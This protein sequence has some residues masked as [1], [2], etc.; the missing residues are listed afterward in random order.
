MSKNIH[1]QVTAAP[2]QNPDEFLPVT[3]LPVCIVSA[4]FGG[5]LLR[6]KGMGIWE[7]HPVNKMHHGVSLD[8]YSWKFSDLPASFHDARVQVEP[9]WRTNNNAQHLTHYGALASLHMVRCWNDY[10]VQ[11]YLIAAYPWG[12]QHWELPWGWP[13]AVPAGDDYPLY[14]THRDGF[15]FGITVRWHIISDSL[16]MTSIHGYECPRLHAIRV[17]YGHQTMT[18]CCTIWRQEDGTY[19][20]NWWQSQYY[21]YA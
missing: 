21:V 17:F 20:V 16:W 4:S 3:T 2:N 12:A 9:F 19:Q 18:P 15:H 6:N 8:N 1:N 5:I 13:L 10:T 14:T 11:A 7:R